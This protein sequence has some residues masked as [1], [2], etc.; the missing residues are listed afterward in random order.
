MVSLIENITS[1]LEPLKTK[2]VNRYM[3]KNHQPSIVADKENRHDNGHNGDLSLDDKEFT[4]I[5]VKALILFLEDFLETRLNSK[6]Y[7]NLQETPSPV[8]PWLRYKQSNDIA[9]K[10]AARAYEH[11]AKASR[12]ITASKSDYNKSHELKD[13]YALIRDLRRLHECGINYLNVSN[14]KE[15][16]N[17]IISAVNN[18]SRLSF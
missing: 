12:G 7:S 1:A 17:S 3:G 16:I 8:S 15:L 18:S 9:P 5:S 13:I 4:T 6:L 2:A 10:K 14:K 11:A